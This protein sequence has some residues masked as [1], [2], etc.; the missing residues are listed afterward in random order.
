MCYSLRFSQVGHLV[1]RLND[2]WFDGNHRF[3]LGTL[4]LLRWCRVGTIDGHGRVGLQLKLST[5]PTNPP[6]QVPV[7]HEGDAEV[8]YD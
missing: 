5:L 4:A 7:E 8:E 6:A 1:R 3:L 2:V